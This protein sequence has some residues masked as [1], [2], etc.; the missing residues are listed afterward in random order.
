MVG[1]GFIEKLDIPIQS[2]GSGNLWK[3]RAVKAK[4]SILKKE[5]EL[6]YYLKIKKNP[7]KV[8]FIAELEIYMAEAN[9]AFHFLPL[10][11]DDFVSLPKLFQW[12]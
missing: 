12:T 11:I 2:Y 8:S 1:S 6:N 3:T 4:M 10:T 5:I 7:L 9:L